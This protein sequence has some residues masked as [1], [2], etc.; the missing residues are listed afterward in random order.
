ME[1]L[2][3]ESPYLN[4]SSPSYLVTPQDLA[5]CSS[6]DAQMNLFQQDR[7]VS[8]YSV[9]GSHEAT[10]MYPMP[11]QD[12]IQSLNLDPA[13]TNQHLVMNQQQSRPQQMK[14]LLATPSSP[15]PKGTS[16]S[17]SKGTP[18][19]KYPEYLTKGSGSLSVDERTM[20]DHS[21]SKLSSH[22][23]DE[24]QVASHIMEQIRKNSG[25]PEKLKRVI[26]HIIETSGPSLPDS[27]KP[28]KRSQVNGPGRN[29]L[30]SEQAKFK[31]PWPDCNKMKK[32]QC[33]LKYNSL[34][35]LVGP[36]FQ[37]YIEQ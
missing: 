35:H 34:L 14:R 22:I 19:I 21:S 20:S 17:N 3:Q 24:D 16:T 5:A 12:I 7:E 6:D 27:K 26:K 23:I 29:T 2:S 36:N 37:F 25:Y 30:P 13:M 28:R 32:T 15:R 18:V 9:N 1:P 31:C 8:P 11:G 10:Y 33:D 4:Q